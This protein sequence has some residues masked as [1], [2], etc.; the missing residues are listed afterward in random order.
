MRFRPTLTATSAAKRAGGFTLA[1]VL[2]ALVFMAIVIPTAI[3][4]LRIANRAGQMGMRKSA[5]A[6]IAERELNELLVTRQWQSGS[7]GGLVQDGAIPY[8][9]NL[10]TEPWK[11]LP[12]LRLLTVQVTFPVQGQDYT[13]RLSTVVDPTV[14]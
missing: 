2:A 4:G 10:R 8:R 9:W 5:A 7:Q 12:V 14:Q 1:E 11:E 3:E 13:L 6:R